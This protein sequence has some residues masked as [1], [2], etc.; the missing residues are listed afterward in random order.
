MRSRFLGNSDGPEV[1]L[2]VTERAP[3]TASETVMSS[4][5]EGLSRGLPISSGSL[6]LSFFL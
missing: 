6:V 1:D 4:H 5:L 2:Y 3:S